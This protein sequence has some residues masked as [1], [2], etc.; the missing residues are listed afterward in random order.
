MSSRD[1][2]AFLIVPSTWAL[3]SGVHV[4]DTAIACGEEHACDQPIKRPFQHLRPQRPDIERIGD[5]ERAAHM[6][7]E[8]LEQ[9]DLALLVMQRL[10]AP[11][12]MHGGHAAPGPQC[13]KPDNIPQSERL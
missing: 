2:P 5:G 1:R 12:S 9:A 11:G 8:K 4:N 6:W 3:G 10:L 13:R 7:S